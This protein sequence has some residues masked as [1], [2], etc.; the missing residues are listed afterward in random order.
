MIDTEEKEEPRFW[1][2][3]REDIH[4]GDF[5]RTLRQDF[6][7]LKDFY[8]SKKQKERLENVGW[9]KRWFLTVFWLLKILMLRLSPTR[10][11]LLLI[12]IILPFINVRVNQSDTRLFILFSGLI[13]L[14]LLMLEL[15]D[16]LLAHHELREGR[17]IQQALMPEKNPEIPGWEVWLF[18]RPAND[19]GGDLV[20]SIQIDKKRAGLTLADVSGKG[21]G[22]ALLMAK[23]QA[24]I[25]AIIP[26]Y[27]S[28]DQL[29]GKINK[30][31]YRDTLRSSFASLVFLE[32]ENKSG[33]IRFINAGHFPPIKLEGNKTVELP[34][35]GSAIG[36]SSKTAFKEQQVTLKKENLLLIYSDGLTEARNSM[37]EF[38]GEKRLFNLLSQAKSSSAK[39]L[40]EDL[41]KEVDRFVGDAR[42][43]DDLSLISL[44]FLG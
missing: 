26:D 5:K 7:E 22:A 4:R 16:K 14:F 27:Q 32:L 30:I 2:T 20:D 24:T 44:K 42:R 41:L 3:V 10:R 28:L 13:L 21:L 35:G 15:K 9:L 40:G 11:L 36:L 33:S 6:A 37:G 12:A 34:K 17:L 8:L 39:G 23:L 18:T 43:N 1:K 29:A 25:K 31:F 19:V 38:F